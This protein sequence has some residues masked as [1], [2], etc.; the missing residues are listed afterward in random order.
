MP[1]ILAIYLFFQQIIQIRIRNIA[2]VYLF[3]G[4]VRLQ[5]IQD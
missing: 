5:A 3:E 2:P 1:I 4:A